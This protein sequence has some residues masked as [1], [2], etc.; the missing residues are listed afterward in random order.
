MHMGEAAHLDIQHHVYILLE[1]KTK[2]PEH[3][4]RP[5]LYPTATLGLPPPHLSLVHFIPSGWSARLPRQAFARV[6]IQDGQTNPI[7]SA[8]REMWAGLET[9]RRGLSNSRIHTLKNCGVMAKARRKGTPLGAAHHGTRLRYRI[10]SLCWE[11]SVIVHVAAHRVQVPLSYSPRQASTR[12]ST[13]EL[14]VRRLLFRWRQYTRLP[15]PDARPV[16]PPTSSSR[17]I[18]PPLSAA[19]I[20]AVFMT[21]SRL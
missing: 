20:P 19:R 8:T 1:Q 11:M 4:R 13:H 17:N 10:H 14:R 16:A 7:G 15:A 5:L 18:L 21:F 2:K 12:S 6:G 3:E 9:D